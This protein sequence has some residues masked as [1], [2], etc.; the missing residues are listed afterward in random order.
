MTENL[1][2]PVGDEADVADGDGNAAG[3]L[4]I[5]QRPEQRSGEVLG[6]GNRASPNGCSRQIIPRT[7]AETGK[8]G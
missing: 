6:R 2:E 1:L 5:S 3:G 7:R 4:E 8:R